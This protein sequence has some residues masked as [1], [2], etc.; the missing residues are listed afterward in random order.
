MLIPRRGIV[1]CASIFGLLE[2]LGMNIYYWL[3]FDNVLI[4][5]C[6]LPVQ[7]TCTAVSDSAPGLE[8]VI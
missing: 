2:K 4:I 6:A 7:F 1:F 5:N 8:L 3:A